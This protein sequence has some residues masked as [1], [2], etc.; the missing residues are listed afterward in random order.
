MNLT[1]DY[2][3]RLVKI[4]EKM[5]ENNI[6]VILAT[7][8]QNLTYIAGAFVPWR[9]VAV[10]SKD[11][12]NKLNT[13]LMDVERIKDDSWM[14]DEDIIPI[15]PLPGMELWDITVQQLKDLGMEK[16]TIGIELGHSPRVGPA[17]FLPQNM[18]C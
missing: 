10:V 5:Q 2:P 11:G 12:F 6:D 7:R 4:R 14:K 1:I 18:N 17:I 9:S 13:L 3:G 15:A 16:A 8:S